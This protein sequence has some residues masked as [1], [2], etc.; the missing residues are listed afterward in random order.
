LIAISQRDYRNVNRADGSLACRMLVAFRFPERPPVTVKVPGL[1]RKLARENPGIILASGSDL[2]VTARPI[3][4]RREYYTSVNGWVNW[5]VVQFT[6]TVRTRE[7]KG[8]STHRLIVD[9]RFTLKSL[10]QKGEEILGVASQNLR[11]SVI[12]EDK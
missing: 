9:R 7:L 6:V 3:S 12:Q 5:G 11:A 10:P 2:E 8:L 1:A 4:F